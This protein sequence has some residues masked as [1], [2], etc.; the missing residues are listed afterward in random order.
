MWLLIAAVVL[1]A[2]ICGAIL[3]I[4]HGPDD[5]TWPPLDDDPLMGAIR[6]HLRDRGR[7]P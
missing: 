4:A 5:G 3:A 1:V 6:R 2:L 7:I